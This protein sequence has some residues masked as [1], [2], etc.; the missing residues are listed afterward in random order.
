[1]NT[2]RSFEMSGISHS[3]QRHT[4]QDMN[5]EQTAV[6]TSHL[7]RNTWRKDLL[8]YLRFCIIV[9]NWG[10]LYKVIGFRNADGGHAVLG[11]G[12]QPFDC[13]FE[14]QWGQRCSSL[15]S[16]VCFVGSGHCDGLITRTEEFCRMYFCVWSR[17]LN[18]EK[19]W[20]QS[21][22][23]C[24]VETMCLSNFHSFTAY[25][26]DEN[27]VMMLTTMQKVKDFP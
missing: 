21:G 26:H 1:M 23:Y 3:T 27:P 12:M 2:L 17:N 18:T 8:S 15:L 10:E 9:I 7:S 20:A 5:P 24:H 14:P 11:V 25:W 16:V 6:R 4:P 13:W 19:A 22:L